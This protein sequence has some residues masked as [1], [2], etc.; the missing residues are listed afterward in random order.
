MNR[1]LTVAVLA[2]SLTTSTARADFTINLNP[3]ANMSQESQD[4]FRAA[5][6]FWE[7]QLIDDVEVNLD[8]DFTTLAPGVLGSAR[9]FRETSSVADY[10]S[11]LTTD[12]TS[13]ADFAAIA[14]LPTLGANGSIAFRTQTNTE[15]TIASTR[16]AI[17]LDNDTSGLDANNNRFLTVN[18]AN[19]K[20]VGLLAADSAG[21][22]ASISFSD[23]FTWDFDRT[24]G[25]N[26]GARDFVGVAIHE[27]GHAF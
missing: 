4:G 3:S 27:I 7:S 10:F 23:S 22:D 9:S 19:L 16:A 20:A 5:A 18:R 25:I 13:R 15:S 21:T 2:V 17:S 6:D 14:N 1:M 8:I 12:A 26:A 11:N 24:D